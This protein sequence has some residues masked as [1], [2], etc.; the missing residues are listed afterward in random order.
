MRCQV[1]AFVYVG[2]ERS[3]EGEAWQE[4]AEEGERDPVGRF[5]AVRC[6]D[7]PDAEQ[8]L[9]AVPVQDGAVL[10]AVA[11][12]DPEAAVRVDLEVEIPVFLL[13]HEEK[14][15]AAV[16]ADRGEGSG[17]FRPDVG[18]DRNTLSDFCGKDTLTPSKR[19]AISEK[20]RRLCGTPYWL[21]STI[22]FTM[23]LYP[24]AFSLSKKR[25]KTVSLLVTIPGTFST[26]TY[27]GL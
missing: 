10:P 12:A 14:L 16:P 6:S 22:S 11:K 24:R 15:E 4:Q 17:V 27:P 20:R 13:R 1:A 2:A 18:L 25:Y 21:I 5:P 8:L 19:V 3:G 26:K 23:F 9:H 7:R